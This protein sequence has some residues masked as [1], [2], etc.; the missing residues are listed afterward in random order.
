MEGGLQNGR[1]AAQ[2]LVL[3]IQRQQPQTGSASDVS[4]VLTALLDS[5]IMTC[6]TT[7][8]LAA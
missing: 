3:P 2:R 8:W 7:Q 6:V 5:A 4:C 1:Y